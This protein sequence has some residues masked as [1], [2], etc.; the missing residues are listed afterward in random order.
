MMSTVRPWLLVGSSI[1]AAGTLALAGCGRVG[2]DGIDRF[3]GGG[4][5][6]GSGSG[7]GSGGGGNNSVQVA[8]GTANA[9][10]LT[11]TLPGPMTAGDFVVIALTCTAC[12]STVTPVVKDSGGDAL[13]QAIAIENTSVSIS[14]SI[15]FAANTAADTGPSSVTVDYSAMTATPSLMMVVVEYSGLAPSAT[16]RGSKSSAST[17]YPTLSSGAFPVT[18][19]DLMFGV[20]TWYNCG[21]NSIAASAGFTLVRPATCNTSVALAAEYQ[22]VTSTGSLAAKFTD[23]T[24]DWY[25]AVGAAFH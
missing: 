22:L 16:L 14:S 23:S 12:D 9:K 20:V 21:G 8:S 24:D 25:A 11:V 4:D 15:F 6:N 18:S 7:S 17:N 1:V 10:L 19:G 2:F 13:A 5:D 3:E